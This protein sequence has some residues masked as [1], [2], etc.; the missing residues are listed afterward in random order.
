MHG[1]DPEAKAAYAILDAETRLEDEG[2]LFWACC[3]LRS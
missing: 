2:T 3:C 1:D